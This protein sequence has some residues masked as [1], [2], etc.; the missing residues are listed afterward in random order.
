VVGFG[1]R[2]SD[3]DAGAQVNLHAATTNTFCKAEPIRSA[4]DSTCV[5]SPRSSHKTANSSRR[6]A[7]TYRRAVA[8]RRRSATATRRRRPRGDRTVV[9]RL[10]PI[11]IDEQDG[12]H[13]A[14][15]SARNMACSRRCIS[16]PRLGKPV[17]GSCNELSGPFRRFPQLDTGLRVDQ[18][19]GSHISQRLR[20]AMA[21]GPA[22]RRRPV[23]VEP[24]SCSSPW[25]RGNVNTAT[26]LPQRSRRKGR[27]PIIPGKSDT[28][29]ASPR[30]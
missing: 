7:P 3:T 13:L 25:R 10:E 12:H 4:M 26:S 22:N 14:G 9:D 28:T 1:A 19:G 17:R 11:E 8:R 23:Q 24:P 18:V 6:S 2:K 29:I 5:A 21:W 30:S 16:R 20:A 15:P 27:K